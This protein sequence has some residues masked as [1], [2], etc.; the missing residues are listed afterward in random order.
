MVTGKD[1]QILAIS[2]SI[3]SSET[4]RLRVTLAAAFFN[5]KIFE[6]VANQIRWPNGGRKHL[7]YV[8]VRSRV[9]FELGEK[10]P[11]N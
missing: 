10:L 1:T 3:T 2:P 8:A 4:L 5:A 11:K 7:V 9:V 6:Y